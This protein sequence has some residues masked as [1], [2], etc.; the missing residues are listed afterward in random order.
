MARLRSSFRARLPPLGHD[1]GA[2]RLRHDLFTEQY[3]FPC[4]ASLLGWRLLRSVCEQC[5]LWIESNRRAYRPIQF[6]PG[7]SDRAG[8]GIESERSV[9]VWDEFEHQVRGQFSQ[10]TCAAM[11][12]LRRKARGL[13]LAVLSGLQRL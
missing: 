3:R 6:S 2:G 12:S 4:I 13:G 9:L 10:S 11:E 7:E 1:G 5:D 8:H